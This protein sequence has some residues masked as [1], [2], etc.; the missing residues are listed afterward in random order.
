MCRSKWSFFI[1]EC[2]PMIPAGKVGAREISNR[3]G[4]K[5]I[6][7]Y[8]GSIIGCSMEVFLSLPEEVLSGMPAILSG[9]TTLTSGKLLLAVLMLILCSKNCIF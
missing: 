1:P 3:I 9:R 5:D 2:N 8:P 6:Q 7:P 4:G